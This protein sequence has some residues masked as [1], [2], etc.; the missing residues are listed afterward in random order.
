MNEN[1]KLILDKIYALLEWY[2][3]NHYKATIDQLLEF[4]D[5]LSI[6]SV[7]MARIAAK[8]KG[9]YVRAFFNRKYEFHVSK[10]RFRSEGNNSTTSEDLARIETG[11]VELEE[12][13]A[14]ENAD[15]INLELRQ[16]NRVLAACQQ[17]ISFEK[18][19]KERNDKLSSYSKTQS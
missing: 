15:I 14:E 5:K 13:A 17:R 7:N 9:T 19:E 2:E 4:Q 10:Q 6:L 16:I 1:D 3:K 18:T 12:I 11:N 8:E